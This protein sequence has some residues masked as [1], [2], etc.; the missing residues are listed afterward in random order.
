MGVQTDML[1]L[2]PAEGRF[3]ERTARLVQ[4]VKAARKLSHEMRQLNRGVYEIEPAAVLS[5]RSSVAAAELILM[6]DE[7]N[8]DI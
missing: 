4:V 6:R 5:L 7:R 3:A 1:T 2:T 8:S